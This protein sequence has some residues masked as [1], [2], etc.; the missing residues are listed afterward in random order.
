MLLQ[1]AGRVRTADPS[2]PVASLP[3]SG[4]TGIKGLTAQLKLRPFTNIA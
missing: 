1:L 2:T 3:T 4:I